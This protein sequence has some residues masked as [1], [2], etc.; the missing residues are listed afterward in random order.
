MPQ[1]AHRRRALGRPHSIGRHTVGRGS[2]SLD[3]HSM[4]EPVAL[5]LAHN[6]GACCSLV[7]TLSPGQ[8]HDLAPWLT[9]TQEGS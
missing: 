2:S 3:W 1:L 7:G 8:C 9:G 4:I 6:E 5:S